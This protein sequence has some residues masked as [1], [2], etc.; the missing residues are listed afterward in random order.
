MKLVLATRNAD[1]INE[2]RAALEGLKMEILTLDRFPEMP[3]LVE[4]GQTL[5]E[6]AIKKARAVCDYTQL[7]CLADDTGLEVD[8]LGGAPGV[9]SSRFAGPEATYDD[10]VEKLLQRLQGVPR[11]QR[12]ARF[13]CVVALVGPTMERVV[14]G[15]CEGIIGEERRGQGGF[16][17]D[18][19]FYVPNLGQTFAEMPL[20]LKN[21]ISHRGRALQKAR[22]ILEQWLASSRQ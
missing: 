17:Y 7:L 10:N 12:T 15:I 18:P 16:G 11:E 20:A 21:G 2:I 4:D 8:F 13:R 5:T 1:K 9:Y 22:V 19:V 3:A 14:E 6:N